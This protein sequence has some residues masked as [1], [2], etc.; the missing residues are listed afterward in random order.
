MKKRQVYIFFLSLLVLITSVG[1][2]FS[3]H[4]CKGNIAALSSFINDEEPCGGNTCC[5]KEENHN[6]CCKTKKISLSKAENLSVHQISDYDFSLSYIL[7]KNHFE[8]KRFTPNVTF[9]SKIFKYKY[10]SHSPPLYKLF[11]SYIFYEINA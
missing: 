1:I 4:F 11:S 3:V 9:I 5:D 2:Q 10:R 7:V 8:L 6:N